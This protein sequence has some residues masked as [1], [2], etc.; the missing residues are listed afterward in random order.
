MKQLGNYVVPSILGSEL[1]DAV[2]DDSSK[3]ESIMM[4]E[5]SK[6]VVPVTGHDKLNIAYAAFDRA[7]CVRNADSLVNQ[8]KKS[9]VFHQLF[10]MCKENGD[11][12][13]I[14]LRR[15][16]KKQV[17][18]KFRIFIFDKLVTG[19]SQFYTYG[20]KYNLS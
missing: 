12:V 20:F 9:R 17:S 2:L 15:Y 19:I 16:I 10:D 3:L 7:H 8:I 13:N 5:L 18:R 1:S 14:V 11:Q 4:E 6:E